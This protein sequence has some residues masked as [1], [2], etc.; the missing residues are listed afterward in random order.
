MLHFWK[1]NKNYGILQGDHAL[2]WWRFL[3]LYNW[4]ILTHLVTIMSYQLS[5]TSAWTR[6]PIWN[7]QHYHLNSFWFNAWS[8][9]SLSYSVKSTDHNSLAVWLMRVGSPW[10]K[11]R[12][13]QQWRSLIYLELSCPMSVSCFCATF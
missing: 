5:L 4:D 6:L 11:E 9:S 1:V 2:N 13:V 7:P 3:S 8:W 12:K 10:N